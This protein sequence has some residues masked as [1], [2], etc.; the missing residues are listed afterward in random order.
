MAGPLAFDEASQ[1]QGVSGQFARTPFLGR[2]LRFQW[3][4][5]I[6]LVARLGQRDHQGQHASASRFGV[7]PQP[8]E[9]LAA[10]IAGFGRL[11]QH[12][13]LAHRVRQ[14]VGCE[15]L[16][17]RAPVQPLRVQICETPT[18]I[19]LQARIG[20]GEPFV[21]A[22]AGHAHGIPTPGVGEHLAR[23]VGQVGPPHL[24]VAD[25]ALHGNR[26][27]QPP[28]RAGHAHRHR[29][30]RAACHEAVV[31]ADLVDHAAFQLAHDR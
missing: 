16:G 25:R 28:S 7:A 23:A 31:E 9:R 19:I 30:P 20:P 2:K 29:R 13:Q 11:H 18:A 26:Q 27:A 5:V 4:C 8:G 3:A 6:A 22:R 14:P 17:D 21:Q 12:F 10:R 1:G 15:G 24:S